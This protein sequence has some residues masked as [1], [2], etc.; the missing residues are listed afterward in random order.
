MPEIII[1][2]KAFQYV[3]Q[4]LAANSLDKD[5]SWSGRSNM[6]PSNAEASVQ[7][8]DLDDCFS[9]MSSWKESSDYVY[10][11]VLDYATGTVY[12]DSP[13]ALQHLQ[14]K[15]FPARGLEDH[16]QILIQREF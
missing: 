15:I 14:E 8:I 10:G 3:G 2:G 7:L 1:N 4:P 13:E 11:Y 9:C 5:T 16:F 12:Y 6:K